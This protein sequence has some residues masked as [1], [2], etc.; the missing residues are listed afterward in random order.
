MVSLTFQLWGTSKA[1]FFLLS[2]FFIDGFARYLCYSIFAL[3]MREISAEA[4]LMSFAMGTSQILRVVPSLLTRWFHPVMPLVI[5]TIAIGTC[6][7]CIL[8][9]NSPG[10]VSVFA[11]SFAVDLLPMNTVLL[12]RL[13]SKHARSPDHLRKLKAHGATLTT[14]SWVFGYS[15]STFIGGIIFESYGFRACVVVT[16]FA[17]TCQLLVHIVLRPLFELDGRL[18][19]SPSHHA[20]SSTASA[21]SRGD[22][23]TKISTNVL[24]AVSSSSQ[25]PE[26]SGA[27]RKNILNNAASTC[28]EAKRPGADDTYQDT[29]IPTIAWVI[30]VG[31]TPYRALTTFL[32]VYFV[33]MY[34][35]LFELPAITACA[36][37]ISAE[38][39]GSAI[40]YIWTRKSNDPNPSNH[41]AKQ[42]FIWLSRTPRNMI[43]GFLGSFLCS[44]GMA[45]S[46][47]PLF[48]ACHFGTGVFYVLL[49]QMTSNALLFYSGSNVE[50]Q[51]L[52]SVNMSLGLLLNVASSVVS[53]YL[54]DI[55][56]FITLWAFACC[57]LVCCVALVVGVGHRLTQLRRKLEHRYVYSAVPNQAVGQ[58]KETR[59][60][61]DGDS[62]DTTRSPVP[63]V[64]D[65]LSQLDTTR[66]SLL[67]VCCGVKCAFRHKPLPHL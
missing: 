40:L 23:G 42:V 44:I 12:G 22:A 28:D 6:I 2:Q 66:L 60:V 46:Y 52:N 1:F 48:I 59:A 41:V 15:L 24:A 10:S 21:E 36:I 37:Q 53:P 8:S 26:L 30:A 33:V 45:T 64:S 11:M 43:F 13:A 63:L 29:G 62:I 65:E 3:H 67:Q 58:G 17:F 51:R 50:H 7:P 34:R 47:L 31:T 16:C 39:S 9:P 56:P 27:N 61:S 55:S 57:A 32:W 18:P 4:K 5:T 49:T 19:A 20:V 14:T 25:P 38:L 54:Y 35:D